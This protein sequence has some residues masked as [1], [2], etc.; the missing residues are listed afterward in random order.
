[1]K[2][3]DGPIRIT[4]AELLASVQCNG[5]DP[6]L[7]PT[8]YERDAT[9]ELGDDGWRVMG[10]THD[11]A[12]PDWLTWSHAPSHRIVMVSE[13]GDGMWHVSVSLVTADGNALEVTA[14]GPFARFGQAV[15]VARTQRRH[16]LAEHQPATYAEQGELFDGAP[17]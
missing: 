14:H 8:Q 17:P 9:G 12:G 10:S 13:W 6:G 11:N 3:G 15:K 7:S 16:I 4:V 2:R 5:V 1:M